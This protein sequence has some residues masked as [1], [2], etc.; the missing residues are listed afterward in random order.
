MKKIKSLAVITGDIINSSGLSKELKQRIKG[1]LEGVT[2]NNSGLKLP[3]Q[4]FRGDSFQLM[5]SPDIAAKLA[6]LIQAT[7]ISMAETFARISIGIG[8]VS[9]IFENDV[10]QSEG[11]AFVLSGHQLDKMKKENRLL[12]IVTNSDKVQMHLEMAFLLVENIINDW[13]PGQASVISKDPQKNTQRVIAAKL[14]IS[15]AA[16]SKALKASKWV[17]VE[18]FLF[19]YMQLVKMMK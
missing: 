17:A 11:E 10:L 6:L 18:Q 3:L 19:W 4:F 2:R 5:C 12:K 8:Q 15:P 9:T 13:K 16:V 7:I 1:E 14:G